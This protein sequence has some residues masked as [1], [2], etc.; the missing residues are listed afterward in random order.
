MQPKWPR[1]SAFA[2]IIIAIFMILVSIYFTPHFVESHIS[3]DG[4]IEKSETILVINGCRIATAI[5]GILI[6]LV[7]II[8]PNF[9]YSV[10]NVLA[11][12]SLK[13]RTEQITLGKSHF[14]Y[15]VMGVCT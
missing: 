7:S 15:K 2:G 11:Q 4:I 12:R 9:F 14:S 3:P 1:I 5:I 6:L 8:R 10:T 13:E